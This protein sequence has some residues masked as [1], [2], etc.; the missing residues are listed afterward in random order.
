[1][2]Y[3][4]FIVSLTHCAFLIFHST[5][6]SFIYRFISKFIYFS[7]VS[8]FLCCYFFFFFFFASHDEN[9]RNQISRVR[10]DPRCVHL[11]AKT[12]LLFRGLYRQFS[13]R[14]YPPVV[15]PKIQRVQLVLL[16]HLKRIEDRERK[17]IKRKKKSTGNRL[18]SLMLKMKFAHKIQFSFYLISLSSRAFFAKLLPWMWKIHLLP[19]YS[20]FFF[21]FSLIFSLSPFFATAW[22]IGVKCD[23]RL[24]ARSWKVDVKE[25]AQKLKKRK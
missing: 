18:N 4:I 10:S 7:Y 23:E 13:I 17:K 12:L 21:S 8:V 1:M 6:D 3:T 24:K 11:K 19:F 16:I 20:M 15:W 9:T 22:N 25:M 2:R 14:L 5:C